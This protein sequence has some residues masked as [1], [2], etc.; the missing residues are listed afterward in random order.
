M[1]EVRSSFGWRRLRH[2]DGK[3]LTAPHIE[4]SAEADD[5]NGARPS[6][7]FADCKQTFGD[8]DGR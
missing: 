5:H 2:E 4:P 7:V 6:D 8:L 3:H 1:G